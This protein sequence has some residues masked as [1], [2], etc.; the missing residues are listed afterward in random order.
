MSSHHV[1]K[2]TD[3]KCEWLCEHSEQLDKRHYWSG[4]RLEE[5]RNLR[6]ENLLPVLLVGKQVDGKHRTY[7]QEEGDVD[8]TSN[9]CASWEYRNQSDEITGEYEEEHREQIRSIR[10]VMLLTYRRLDE[11]I[12]YRHHYHLHSTYKS[13]WSLALCVVVLIPAGTAKEHC[14]EYGHH[15]PD[16]QHTLGD[17][18]VKWA[19]LLASHA[20]IYLAV[21]LLAEEELIGQ[22]VS[23]TEEPLLSG[24]ITRTT[25]DDGQRNADVMALVA[26]DMPFVRVGQVLEYNLRDVVLLTFSTL[27]CQGGSRQQRYHH[28][29]DYR[30]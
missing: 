3:H 27:A 29:E 8:V 13:L 1:G 30:S 20:L 24:I 2:E 16:L 19:N 28:Q 6:P 26:G 11:V 21:M 9:V 25:K 12:M 18:E 15:N 4:I 17:A 10:F 5:Q 23:G 22:T 7:S 14:Y